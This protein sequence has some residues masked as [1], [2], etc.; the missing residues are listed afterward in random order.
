MSKRLGG[1]VGE[2]N[3]PVALVAKADGVHVCFM[4]L[5]PCFRASVGEFAADDFGVNF[6]QVFLL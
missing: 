4:Q 5:I 3:I 1:G 2:I 6:V